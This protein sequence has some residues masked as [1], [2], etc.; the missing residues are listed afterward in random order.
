MSNS[1]KVIG[2]CLVVVGIIGFGVA[3]AQQ[4]AISEPR[5]LIQM[6]ILLDTSGS[7]S[8]LIDQARAELWAIVNEFIYACKDGKTPE[9]QVAFLNTAKVP[10]LRAAAISG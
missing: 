1:K 2:L 5:P 6:A 9:F 10:L 8:G 7:M 3:R 4:P